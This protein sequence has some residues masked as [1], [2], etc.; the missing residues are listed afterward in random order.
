MELATHLKGSF[1]LP[2]NAGGKALMDHLFSLLISEDQEWIV[3]AWG[4]GARPL[5]VPGFRTLLA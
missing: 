2:H 4:K 3:G 5:C 1:S